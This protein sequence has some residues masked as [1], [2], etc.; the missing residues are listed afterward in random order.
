MGPN[1]EPL[2]S[3]SKGGTHVALEVYDYPHFA[4]KE[5]EVQSS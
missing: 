3:R 1:Q 4:D 5:T 2:S